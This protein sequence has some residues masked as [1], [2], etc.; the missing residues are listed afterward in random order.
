MERVVTREKDDAGTGGVHDDCSDS[1]NN[2]P[3]LCIH[4]IKARSFL[5]FD[6]RNRPRFRHFSSFSRKMERGMERDPRFLFSLF[7]LEIETT[8]GTIPANGRNPIYCLVLRAFFFFFYPIPV[9]LV[10]GVDHTAACNVTHEEAS[11]IIILP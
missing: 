2:L 8:G 3:D 10:G 4:S 6:P 9:D 7:S 11:R 1:S 5:I